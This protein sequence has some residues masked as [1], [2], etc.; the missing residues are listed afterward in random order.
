M[1][2]GGEYKKNQMVDQSF[3]Y[4]SSLF[5]LFEFFRIF[6]FFELEILS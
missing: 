1:M 6:Q 5:S 4:Y 2:E 3:L